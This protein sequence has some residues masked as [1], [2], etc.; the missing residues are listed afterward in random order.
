MAHP[1]AALDDVTDRAALGHVVVHRFDLPPSLVGIDVAAPS[2]TSADP[3]DDLGP[4][5]V[6]FVVGHLTRL[7]H[8]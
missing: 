7:Q 6:A 5:C 3:V 8:G 2:T 4:S 1:D